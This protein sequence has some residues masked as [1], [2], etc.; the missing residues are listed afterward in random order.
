M[1]VKHLAKTLA[2]SKCLRDTVLSI[3]I[4][5]TALRIDI[6]PTRE[7]TGTGSSRSVLGTIC[8]C[9]LEAGRC[10]A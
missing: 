8:R 4:I 5:D 9:D 6:I 10:D 3:P 7:L 1:E 2:Q